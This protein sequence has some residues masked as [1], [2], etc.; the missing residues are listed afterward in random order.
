MPIFHCCCD[1]EFLPARN[2]GER[3]E[4]KGESAQGLKDFLTSVTGSL[5]PPSATDYSMSSGSS[6]ASSAIPPIGHAIGG[7]IGSALA[8]LLFYPLERARIEMQADAGA[9]NGNKV[10]IATAANDNK[11]SITTVEVHDDSNPAESNLNPSCDSS[12]ESWVSCVDPQ[13]QE[14][15]HNAS[16]CR[17]CPANTADSFNWTSSYTF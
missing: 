12:A 3:E 1:K 4:N 10:S 14:Q 13:Q 7:S 15:T 6:V 11:V 8:L 9:A 17:Y 16:R 2:E 5:E